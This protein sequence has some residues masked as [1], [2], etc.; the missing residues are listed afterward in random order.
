MDYWRPEVVRRRQEQTSIKALQSSSSDVQEN[1]KIKSKS[2][3]NVV[4]GQSINN[5]LCEIQVVQN[6]VYMP[7]WNI[8]IQ[9]YLTVTC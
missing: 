8:R 4:Q 2:N 5:K 6:I 9:I 1:E 3:I 7:E